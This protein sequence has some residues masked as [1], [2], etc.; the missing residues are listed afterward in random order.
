MR[1]KAQPHM[2]RC[3]SSRYARRMAQ[4]P[5]AEARATAKVVPLPGRDDNAR[6]KKQ[7]P[8]ALAGWA[9]WKAVSALCAVA[10][11]TATVTAGYLNHEHRL[12]SLEEKPSARVSERG[13]DGAQPVANGATNAAGSELACPPG[14]DRYPATAS[15]MRMLLGHE[16][17]IVP[18]AIDSTPRPG[19]LIIGRN[20]LYNEVLRES[21]VSG[22]E[23]AICW[24][25]KIPFGVRVP[26]TEAAPA[27]YGQHADRFKPPELTDRFPACAMP[28]M[29]CTP[30]SNGDGS[31]NMT[32]CGILYPRPEP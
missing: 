21:D 3:C 6:A 2:A 26:F 23:L 22:H 17:P 16:A 32:K 29:G 11:V 8:R 18:Y 30:V 5:G 15:N 13:L 14:Y 20:I 25:H 19:H 12:A 9:G 1:I 7:A 24:P 4:S 10:G 28:L 27:V 31:F